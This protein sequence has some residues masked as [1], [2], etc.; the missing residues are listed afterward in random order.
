ML[1]MMFIIRFYCVCSGV[2]WR[3]IYPLS[4]LKWDSRQLFKVKIND[5]N[6][7]KLCISI[8]SSLRHLFQPL[9]AEKKANPGSFFHGYGVKS[10]AVIRWACI[11]SQATSTDC[12]F[13]FHWSSNEHTPVTLFHHRVLIWFIT[14]PEQYSPRQLVLIIIQKWLK[15]NQFLTIREVLPS[16]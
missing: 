14:S 2:H 6:I 11:L 15:Y 7:N 8:S 9:A 5:S 12:I 1:I 10:A 13:K 3:S 4:I 16:F